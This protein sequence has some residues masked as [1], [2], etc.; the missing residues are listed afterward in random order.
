MSP[1]T[2]TRRTLVYLGGSVCCCLWLWGCGE[3]KESDDEATDAS[4]PTSSQTASNTNAT[5]AASTGSG[6]STTNGS[7]ASVS[8]ASGGSG[9]GASITG[10]DGAS[11]GGS[12]GANGTIGSGGSTDSGGTAGSGG[13]TAGTGGEPNDCANPYDGPI[14]GP[15]AEGPEMVAQVCDQVSDEDILARYKDLD[16]KVPQGLYWEPPGTLS[17]WGEACSENPAETL[18]HANERSIGD[19]E[20][21]VS[22]DWSYEVA[23]CYEGSRRVYSD[24]SCDYF[25]GTTLAGS[26]AEDLAYLASLLWWIDNGNLTGAQILGYASMVGGATDLILLCTIRT[27][28]GDFGLCDQITLQQTMHS[29]TVDGAVSLG[30]PDT[31]RT[32]EG[33]C[34]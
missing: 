34:N 3:T 22:S 28:F 4:G 2:S 31:V 14:G 15:R 12:A 1:R 8:T 27:S 6:A 10:T 19:V 16:R 32:I 13:G 21:Q 30:E 25:D 33:D 5:N 9:G 23:G 11:D 29:I 18:D 26:T 20:G 7:T 17:W 24:L